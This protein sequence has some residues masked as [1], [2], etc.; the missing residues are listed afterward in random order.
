MPFV[1]L[2]PWT[3]AT[4]GMLIALGFF[5]GYYVFSAELRRRSLTRVQPILVVAALC[6][7]GICFSKLATILENPAR[8]AA[9]PAALLS[10]SG[11]TFY[12]GMLGDFLTLA[13]LARHYRTPMASLLDALAAPLALGYAIGRMA[14]FFAGD[15]DYGIPTDLPWGMRFPEGLVPALQPVHPTPLYEAAASAALA[16]LLWRL[17]SPRRRLPPFLVFS[18]Y[19]LFSGLARFAV[20]FLK[21]NPQ[22]AF[23]LVA[24]QLLAAV[25]MAVGLVGWWR[26]RRAPP[27]AGAAGAT[28]GK[29]P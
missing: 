12:G 28:P 1:H 20:E 16:A 3:L 9:D 14:C 8:F 23:G 29:G 4:Y 27:A 2:G 17:G 7:A 5:C 21:R 26:A 6:L 22:V 25:S 15:G 13:L 19:L 18:V 11:Y 24:A 10:R